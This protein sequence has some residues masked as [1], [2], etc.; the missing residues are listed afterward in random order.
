LEGTIR[1][2][3]DQ[4]RSSRSATAQP[5]KLTANPEL[6][7]VR[8]LLTADALRTSTANT[9]LRTACACLAGL[10]R[11]SSRRR[12]TIVGVGLRTVGVGVRTISRRRLTSG[13][14]PLTTGRRDSDS[15][16]IAPDLRASD[17]HR[18]PSASDH[19]PSA[20]DYR[21]SAF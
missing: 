19:R 16:A 2:R 14:Q 11:T 7:T 15:W 9:R 12:F 4:G 21:P 5:C 3:A 6:R 8:A 20:S 13:R 17:S 18:W 1:V 10:R